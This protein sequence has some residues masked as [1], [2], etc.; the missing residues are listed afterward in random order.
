MSLQ[1]ADQFGEV[2]DPR[3]SLDASVYEVL[4]W[5]GPV[6]TLTRRTTR[7]VT[8]SGKDLPTRAMLVVSITSAN[9]DESVFP[10]VDEFDVRSGPD[11]TTTVPRSPSCPPW[12]GRLWTCSSTGSRRFSQRPDGSV[13]A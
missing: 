5:S 9:R 6:G 10:Y 8:L 1:C 7:P 11:G 12:P 3:G 2:R 4:R 13:T